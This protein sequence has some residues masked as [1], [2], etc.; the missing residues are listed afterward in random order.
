MVTYMFRFF[1][2]FL[3]SKLYLSDQVTYFFLPMIA[4]PTA[5][6][7]ILYIMSRGNLMIA[8]RQLSPACLP[9]AQNVFAKSMTFARLF[10]G[11]VRV[12][13]F[14]CPRKFWLCL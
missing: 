10:L 6:W 14:L 8:N 12:T 11:I 3:R 5:K 4:P 2:I 1:N 13:L 9:G 7:I